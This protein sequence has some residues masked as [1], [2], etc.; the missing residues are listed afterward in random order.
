[1][2]FWI[3]KIISTFFLPPVNLILIG[4]LGLLFLKKKP[5]LGKGLILASLVMLS[6]LSLPWVAHKLMT[7][8][9]NDPAIS[10][11]HREAEAI[12]I[13][14][15]GIYPKAPEY[16]KDTISGSALER[17]RY[18]A[19]LHRKTGKPILVTGGNPSRTEL[20]EGAI[21]KEV[22]KKEFGV[23]VRWVE[24]KSK[25]TFENAHYSRDI[26]IPKGID[27]IYLVTHAHHM[28]RAKVTFERFGFKVI[29]APTLFPTRSPL[30]ILD[31][32]P[33]ASAL[34]TSSNV[35]HEWI[36]RIWYRFKKSD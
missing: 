19:T 2:I 9:P 27:T 16:G 36:G 13:L 3:P 20:T 29:P 7:T 14:G 28:P 15:A 35:F 18:G 25:T 32:L 21:M 24:D 33:R 26:L 11:P 22:L 30:S 5:R 6:I 1:M 12:V 17:I 23:P 4:I 34:A 31:F 10:T 8:L